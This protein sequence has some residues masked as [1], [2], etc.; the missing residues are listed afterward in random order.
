M[1]DGLVSGIPA[2]RHL[3]GKLPDQHSEAQPSEGEALGSCSTAM[4]RTRRSWIPGAGRP[5]PGA[6]AR[7][8]AAAPTSREIWHGDH[9]WGSLEA[10]VMSGR[11]A[12][13]ECSADA[14][15]EKEVH[16]REQDGSWRREW[17][18]RE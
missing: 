4:A 9:D 16:V 8:L 15:T 12:P 3:L 2:P 10:W 13:E 18:P 5:Q 11:P 6:A 14:E 17:R 1:A 7:E